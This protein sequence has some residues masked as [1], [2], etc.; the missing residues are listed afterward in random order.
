M[1]KEIER[2]AFREIASRRKE[3]QEER[4]E[5][6]RSEAKA[7]HPQWL[8]FQEAVESIKTTSVAKVELDL[9]N[10]YGTLTVKVVSDQHYVG[11]ENWNG[12]SW[13]PISKALYDL[14]IQE[15]GGS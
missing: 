14:L 3:Q 13:L 6:M 7:G 2:P 1:T 10:Y 8:Q 12:W 11:L 5:A 9:G 4:L 15:L